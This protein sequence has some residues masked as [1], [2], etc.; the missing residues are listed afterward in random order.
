MSASPFNKLK[1][2][3]DSA[4]KEHAAIQVFALPDINGVIEL[5]VIRNIKRKFFSK[6]I[7]EHNFFLTIHKNSYGAV[8]LY[9]YATANIEEVKQIFIDFI[10]YQ[11]LPE[12]SNW[13]CTR[14]EED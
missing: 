12:L 1:V 7:Q 4:S 11:K 14:I 6:E 3:F 2:A 8:E 13:V 10:I 5:T 9:N